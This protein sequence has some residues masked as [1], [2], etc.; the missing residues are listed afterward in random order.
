MTMKKHTVQ[1]LHFISQ[2]D[3]ESTPA[4][5]EQILFGMGCFWGAER[6]F[7]KLT[8]VYSTAVGYSGGKTESP[9]YKDVCSGSTDHVEVVKVV[10]DPALISLEELLH[11]FWQ[12][13]NPTQ[14]MRQG[15]DIGTQYRSVIYTYNKNQQ[16][17]ATH[18]KK[19]YQ[20]ALSQ[21]GIEEPITT[22][23]TP[24][25]DFYFAE[26]YHQQY[27]AKNPNGYCG[28]SGTGVCFL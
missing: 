16:E 2:H 28:L 14:G 1:P 11:S 26:E 18:T 20:H 8:G 9:T 21:Q 12:T 13:H 25:N 10:F 23:I 6:L 22:E 17:I 15:N 19:Q 3:I 24:A 27:L 4:G 5:F 7:W